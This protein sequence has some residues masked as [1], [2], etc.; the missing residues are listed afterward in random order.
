MAERAGNYGRVA[1]RLARQVEVALG[2]ADVSMSQ[3][4]ILMLLDEGPAVASRLAEHLA[5]T[6]PTVTAVVDGLVAR[7]LVQ[8]VHPDDGDRRRIDLSLTT[9]GRDLLEH[10]EASVEARVHEVAGFL[11]DA[12]EITQALEG[13]DLWREALDGHRAEKLRRRS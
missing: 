2:K 4:R 9:A 12:D 13:L 11:D 10:A 5:V 8:R 3:Y 6:R 7:G 1:A